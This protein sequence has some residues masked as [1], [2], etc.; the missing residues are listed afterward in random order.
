MLNIEINIWIHGT[1]DFPVSSRDVTTK[2]SQAGNNLIMVRD[3][4]A[5]DEVIASLF[6]SVEKAQEDLKPV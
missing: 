5:G 4:L 6:Y 2:L 3:I 1:L